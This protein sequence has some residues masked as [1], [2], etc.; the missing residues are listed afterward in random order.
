MDQSEIAIAKRKIGK[1]KAQVKTEQQESAERG[2]ELER[3]KRIV[4]GGVDL[5][6][7]EVHKLLCE[8]LDEYKKRCT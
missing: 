2:N 4:D 7:P 6:T 1:L 3:I 8:P 5:M